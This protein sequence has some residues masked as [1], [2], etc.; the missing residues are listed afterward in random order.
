VQL[1]CSKRELLYSYR[2]MIAN[3]AQRHIDS[4]TRD[5]LAD[6]YTLLFPDD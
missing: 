1:E 6:R 5:T 4:K 2:Y 3:T